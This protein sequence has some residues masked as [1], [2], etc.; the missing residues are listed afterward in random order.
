[1]RKVEK[2]KLEIERIFEKKLEREKLVRDIHKITRRKEKDRTFEI[3]L[4]IET[5]KEFW[6]EAGI[7]IENKEHKNDKSKS[8]ELTTPEGRSENINTEEIEQDQNKYKLQTPIPRKLIR[9]A[10]IAI[11]EYKQNDSQVEIHDNQN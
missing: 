8:Q 7:L 10:R 1:M 5:N 9:S 4:F 3:D 2:E 11:P 6:K